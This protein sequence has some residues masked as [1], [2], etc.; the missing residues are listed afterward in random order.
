MR[1]TL[2][3]TDT[4][5]ILQVQNLNLGF[6][7]RQGMVNVL[8]GISFDLHCGRKWVGQVDNGASNSE[9][10]ASAGHYK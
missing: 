6:N 4:S 8:H 9:Y 10:G 3:D 7:M 2:M 1:Q 5:P